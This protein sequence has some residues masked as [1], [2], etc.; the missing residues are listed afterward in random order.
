MRSLSKS[1]RWTT[2]HYFPTAQIKKNSIVIHIPRPLRVSTLC[3]LNS[4]CLSREQGFNPILLFKWG[5]PGRAD[6]LCLSSRADF[7]FR[8]R[9]CQLYSMFNLFWFSFVCARIMLFSSKVGI[10]ERKVWIETQTNKF[11]Q[12]WPMSANN[13]FR[14]PAKPKDLGTYLSDTGRDAIHAVSLVRL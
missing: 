4:A 11:E 5:T 1:G 12:I 10:R 2:F 14:Y 3:F 9:S 7:D 13:G 6:C 8:I